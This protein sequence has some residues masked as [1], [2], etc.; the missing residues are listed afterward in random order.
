MN[1]VALDFETANELRNSACSIGL[2]RV[3]NGIVTER[4]YTLI[5]PEPIRFSY[6][7]IKI[8]GIRPE[9]VADAPTF[10]EAWPEIRAFIGSDTV[11]AHN[12]SFDMSVLRYSL[13]QYGLPYPE[14]PYFC[15]VTAAK[16]AF[17]DLI[18]HKLNTV[19]D[20]VGFRFS[21]HNALEDAEAC[22][23]VLIA[24]IHETGTESLGAFCKCI[25]S[26]FGQLG[27]TAQKSVR[28]T[29]AKPSRW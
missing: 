13:D 9:D 29:T 23:R 11:V 6:W 2:V 22:A 3:E 10:G 1:F 18:N 14:I 7:N 5:K 17:P 27:A 26:N 15:T 25:C 19:S 4:Y 21:H 28:K 20:H 16:R 8:H 24:A 12:A